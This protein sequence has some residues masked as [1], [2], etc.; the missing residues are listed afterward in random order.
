MSIHAAVV[1]KWGSPP[2]Y[3]LIDL[4]AP[5]DTQ[6]R[7][8]VL[9]AGV[10]TF[11]RARASGKHFSM[12]GKSPPHVPGTDGVGIVVETNQLVYFN[13]LLASTGSIAQEINVGKKDIF[14]L[15]EGADADTVAVLV[16]PAMSA[17][18]GATGVSGQAAVQISKAFGASKIVAIGKPGTKLDKTKELGAT[19]T[20]SL[21]ED[22]AQ[23]DFSGA[24]DVD[25]VLDYLWGDVSNA[26]MA[27]IIKGRELPNQRLSW[28]EIGSLAG[29]TQAVPASLLRQANVALLGC[30][31]GAWSFPELHAQTPRI[32]EAIVKGGFKSE[33]AAKNLDDVE[34]WWDEVSH[35]RL[36]VKP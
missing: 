30:A 17:I 24:T 2:T 31:P 22:L 33:Y 26:A 1:H 9:A 14:P 11:V 25:V 7:I 10:H 20:I 29:E 35:A 16:N 15:P 23:T 4:P 12:A 8:K 28:V 6:V 18:I 32:L 27:G 19:A 36:L 21:S 3:S 5:S 34:T 13:A